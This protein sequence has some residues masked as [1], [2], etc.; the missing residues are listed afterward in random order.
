[1]NQC[2]YQC[3]YLA[4]ALWLHV[5]PVCTTLSTSGDMWGGGEAV[6]SSSFTWRQQKW[7]QEP[8]KAENKDQVKTNVCEATSEDALR[9][10][11]DYLSSGDDVWG[12]VRLPAL[13][14]RHKSA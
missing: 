1:M 3:V 6:V 11:W 9:Q 2:S 8:K 5:S 12:K 14:L 13:R 4:A 7:Q 10:K